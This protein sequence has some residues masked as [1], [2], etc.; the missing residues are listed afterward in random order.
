ME[1]LINHIVQLQELTLI[2]D[3][4]KASSHTHHLEQLNKS[5][6]TMTAELPE[7]E[8]A[9]YTKLSKKD[10]VVIVPVTDN[11]CTGC[12][13]KLPISLVQ[14]VRQKKGVQRCPNCARILYSAQSAPKRVIQR[15][16]RSAPRKVGVNRFSSAALMVPEIEADSM[17]DCIKSFAALMEAEG[18]INDAGKLA[19]LAMARES[20]LS[21]VVDHGMAFPHVRGVEGGALAFAMG[22]S[23][24][25]L[26]L[27]DKERGLTH[28]VFFIVIPTAA[29]A[30]YL[31]LLAGLTET[32][33]N[34]EA[35][36]KI[37]AET[38]QA[39]MWKALVKM[40]RPTIK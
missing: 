4:Q 32:F 9:I 22:K 36:E 3:E 33:R 39:G 28:V 15:V 20:V 5:I 16:K 7:E 17:D 13:M 37:M 27:G 34:P 11:N 24:A 6:A 1:S 14:V 38:T 21:T 18:F 8:Q 31:K 26:S 12:G 10:H 25:G 40:T 2:R 23:T 30:F 35:V 19:D 29:S